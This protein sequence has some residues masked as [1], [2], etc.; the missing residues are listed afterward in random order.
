MSGKCNGVKTIIETRQ[1]LAFYTH[2]GAHYMKTFLN[3]RM[4]T[5]LIITKLR[6]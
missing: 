3:S 6:S 2:R 4:Y 5:I 1:P